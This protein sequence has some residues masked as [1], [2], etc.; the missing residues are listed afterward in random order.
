MFPWIS[1][2]NAASK[3]FAVACDKKAINCRVSIHYDIVLAGELLVLVSNDE[4]SRGYF[5]LF[6]R[7]LSGTSRKSR[8]RVGKLPSLD[9]IASG[10]LAPRPF[11]SRRVQNYAGPV[12]ETI[13]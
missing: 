6:V 8:G 4:C 1:S 13:T 12:K 9:E 5:L 10:P 7:M 11:S 2:P 3:S